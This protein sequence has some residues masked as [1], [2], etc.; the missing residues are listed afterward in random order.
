MATSF[1]GL[2]V[3]LV[4]QGAST[5]AV[6]PTLGA[7][8]AVAAGERCAECGGR[9]VD[10]NG[11]AMA[12]LECGYQEDLDE[13]ARRAAGDEGLVELCERYGVDLEV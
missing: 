3:V 12:C 2:L 5:E 11:G 6:A 13:A 1:D 4:T 10:T 7:V 9:E 8:A